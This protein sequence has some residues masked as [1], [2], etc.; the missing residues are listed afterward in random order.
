LE[1]SH[2]GDPVE[3]I[4]KLTTSYILRIIYFHKIRK[5][6]YEATLKLLSAYFETI[7][8]PETRK[9]LEN[10]IRIMI[11]GCLMM[12]VDGISSMWLP[13]VHNDTKKEIVRRLAV[14]LVLEKNQLSI[15]DIL[16]Q[17]NII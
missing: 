14:K 10:R 8:I 12:R 7:N 17:A 9:A 1:E 2:W 15:Q 6:A 5:V 3:D 4:G 11:A 16:E 13:W